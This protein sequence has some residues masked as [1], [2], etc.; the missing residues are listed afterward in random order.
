M[1]WYLGP[2]GDQRI[3]YESDEIEQIVSDELR[4]AGLT[5]NRND[6]VV[7]LERFIEDHLGC[8]LD[9]YAQLPD[10]VLGMTRFPA[11]HRP[12]VSI[13]ASLTQACDDERPAPGSLGR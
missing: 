6:P 3:W 2:D 9:Q 8:E 4:R 10:D 13:N 7:D 5:P 12:L 11:N 1:Q